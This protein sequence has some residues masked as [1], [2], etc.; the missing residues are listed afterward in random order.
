[1]IWFDYIVLGIIAYFVIRGIL[2]GFIKT[3]FSFIGMIT[4]FL[5]SGWLSL[6]INPYIAKFI[7]NNPKLFPIIGVILS[8]I[9]IYLS[10]VFL[11]WLIIKILKTLNLGFVD[12]ILGGLLGFIKA[13]LLITFLYLLFTLSYPPIKKIV[14]KSYTYPL[15]NYTLN[16]S[17]RFIPK[18]WKDFLKTHKIPFVDFT[19]S[20]PVKEIAFLKA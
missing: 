17:S 7:T 10:F 6:K 16:I 19:V 18:E 8:F 5:F 1:M 2:S 9:I 15:I 4:A 13:C 14:K 20:S 3:I 12:R 11:G